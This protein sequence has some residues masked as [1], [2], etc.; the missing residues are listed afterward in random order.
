[1][2][3]DR[4]KKPVPRS[5]K[6]AFT[7]GVQAHEIGWVKTGEGPLLEGCASDCIAI[8]PSDQRRRKKPNPASGA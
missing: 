4:S 8:A 1:M 5:G 6:R 2:Q 3:S 7:W